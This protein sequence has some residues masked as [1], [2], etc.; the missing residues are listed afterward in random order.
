MSYTPP[1]IPPFL[2]SVSYNVPSGYTQFPDKIPINKM[3]VGAFSSTGNCVNVMPDTT[4]YNPTDF[5]KANPDSRYCSGTVV[6]P[7]NG[8]IA[9]KRNI[10]LDNCAK[11]CDTL[12]DSCKLFTLSNSTSDAYLYNYRMPLDSQGLTC[13]LYDTKTT[14]FDSSGGNILG[15]SSMVI[16]GLEPNAISFTNTYVKNSMKAIPAIQRIWIIRGGILSSTQDSSGLLRPIS[17][18]PVRY[19]S[20]TNDERVLYGIVPD[21]NDARMGIVSASNDYGNTWTPLVKFPAAFWNYRTRIDS[22]ISNHLSLKLAYSRNVDNN[23]AAFL[24]REWSGGLFRIKS[25]GEWTSP[26]GGWYYDYTF[27]QHTGNVLAVYE[28][29]Y[30]RDNVGAILPGQSD[31]IITRRLYCTTSF[32]GTESWDSFYP[33]SRIYIAWIP[34]NLGGTSGQMSFGYYSLNLLKGGAFGTFSID[35]IDNITRLNLPAEDTN[36]TWNGSTLTHV[37]SKIMVDSSNNLVDVIYVL[38]QNGKLYRANYN[39][40]EPIISTSPFGSA[41]VNWALVSESVQDFSIVPT[42]VQRPPA[43]PGSGCIIC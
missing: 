31:L 5:Y 26:Y 34:R 15:T 16:K 32:F 4:V 6:N 40:D 14:S 38:F 22:S 36:Y 28:D 20:A 42:F 12:G 18:G 13:N 10:T 23:I 9:V 8:L 11:E 29:G 33:R 37:I 35:K 25:D 27:E 17:A 21:P 39:L 7:N 19:I 43:P 3:K 2:P 41:N 30:I 1:V 24:V